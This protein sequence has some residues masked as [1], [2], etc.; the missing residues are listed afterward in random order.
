MKK[1]LAL[2]AAA[3]LALTSAVAAESS[4]DG[5][6]IYGKLDLGYSVGTI[7]IDVDSIS[8]SE[9]FNGFEVTPAL[10]LAPSFTRFDGKP[11]DLT[12][13]LALDM[14]FGTSSAY[15]DVTVTVINPEFTAF[16]NWHFEDSDSAFLQ[17]FTPYAGAGFA[18]PIQIVKF[19]YETYEVYYTEEK[20]GNNQFSTTVKT[21]H[22]RTVSED[23]DSTV[24]G[25]DL[26]FLVGARYAISD[27]FEVNAETGYNCISMNNWFLHAGA[28]YHFK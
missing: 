11:F 19:T 18:L 4:S 27:K 13:E 10:G 22:T 3:A 14:I 15:D 17:K 24:V 5:W 28:L 8:G 25:F 9:A 1:T 16:F 7:Q 2:L 6:G 23:F 21:P 20:V 12:F 26:T